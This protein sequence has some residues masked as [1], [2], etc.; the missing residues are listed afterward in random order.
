MRHQK[1]LIV[2]SL[3]DFFAIDGLFASPKGLRFVL[4]FTEVVARPLFS[5][6]IEHHI[7][8]PLAALLNSFLDW[9]WKSELLDHIH[10]SFD[11]LC[12]QVD[13]EFSNETQVDFKA[14]IGEH[15]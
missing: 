3:F 10:A 4:L 7:E 2:E 12:S 13:W 15:E 5:I 9:Q 8:L 1:P 14:L 11:F 6:G